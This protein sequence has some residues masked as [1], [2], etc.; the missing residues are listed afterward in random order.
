MLD[1]ALKAPRHVLAVHT[2]TTS[3]TKKK[4]INK[5]SSFEQFTFYHNLPL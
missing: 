2:T 3:F 5:D 1:T 4:K